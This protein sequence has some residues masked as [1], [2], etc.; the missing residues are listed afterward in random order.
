MQIANRTVVVIGSTGGIGAEI[1]KLLANEGWH[2]ALVNRSQEKTERQ[3]SELREA[4]PRSTFRAYTA[5]MMDL[6]QIARVT[7]Q[8][9][10]EC[11]GIA[12]L[13][14]VAG[15]LTNKRLT[16]EQGVEGHFAV[17]TLAPYLFTQKLRA[18]LSAASSAEH[19]SFVVNFSSSA[20]GG[21]RSL[22]VDDLANPSEIGGLFGAYAK[23]KLAITVATRFLEAELAD[24]GVLIHAV[25]PGATKTSMTGSGD[26]MPWFIRLLQPVL[27]KAAD[28]QARKLVSAI[29]RAV[30]DGQSGLYIVEGKVKTPPRLVSDQTTQA[31]LRTLLERYVEPYA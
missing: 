22:D 28:A 3:I 26:G 5:D 6:S 12:G 10:S 21:V 13:Y 25:D 16:S 14:L 23:T 20:I 4:H 17:N 7:E 29:D 9:R 27:F 15:L 19:K 18:T 24:E 1:A 11:T 31:K 30:T 8:I 2:L